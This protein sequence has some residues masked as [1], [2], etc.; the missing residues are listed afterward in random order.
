M[1]QPNLAQAFLQNFLGSSPPWYKHTIVGFLL[2]LPRLLWL[3]A[4]RLPP[5]QP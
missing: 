4:R 3:K 1:S 2:R 5:F